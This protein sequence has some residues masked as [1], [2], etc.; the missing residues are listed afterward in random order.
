MSRDYIKSN[1]V[2]IGLDPQSKTNLYDYVASSAVIPIDVFY[3]SSLEQAISA[4]ITYL[5]NKREGSVYIPADVNNHAVYISARVGKD[6]QVDINYSTVNYRFPIN[7]EAR[8]YSG[9]NWQ[10]GDIIINNDISDA[11]CEGWV[12][13]EAG[14]PGT[15]QAF[16]YIRRWFT[17]IEQLD[18]LPEPGPMQLSRQVMSGGRVYICKLVDG[19]YAWYWMDYAYGTT[20][21][22]PTTDLRKGLP[23]YNIQTGLPEW[24]NGNEWVAVALADHT[25]DSDATDPIYSEMELSSAD[26]EYLYLPDSTEGFCDIQVRASDSSGANDARLIVLDNKFEVSEL[27]A[28]DSTDSSFE[29][30]DGSG[31]NLVNSVG[32]KEIEVCK[33]DLQLDPYTKYKYSHYQEF[34]SASTKIKIDIL[35]TDGIDETES[36]SI[37]LTTSD[38]YVTYD[39]V[40]KR[41]GRITITYIFRSDSSINDILYLS[42]IFLVPATGNYKFSLKDYLDSL[43][44]SSLY[45]F[46][47]IDNNPDELDNNLVIKRVGT[48]LIND[49]TYDYELVNSDT[50]LED[51]YLQFQVNLIGTAIGDS[52][53]LPTSNDTAASLNL[54]TEF[55]S[56]FAVSAY[57]TVQAGSSSQAL[58]GLSTEG[59]LLYSI[60][61]SLIGDSIISNYISY[62]TAIEGY[63][64][65]V[66]KEPQVT[67]L[68]KYPQVVR[69]YR[70]GVVRHDTSSSMVINLKYPANAAATS[71]SNSKTIDKLANQS[72]IPGNAPVSWSSD[73]TWD[74]AAQDNTDWR[75]NING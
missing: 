66:Y 3:Q 12:C 2:Q 32:G 28:V 29:L 56:R 16:G 59:I 23:Y 20:A 42:E 37:D 62:I 7:S 49:P 17:E 36:D 75:G 35:G 61:K 10:I 15:W 8:P 38:Q 11:K 5:T 48:T 63:A 25:H 43:G 55:T 24:Y 69:N 64:K 52:T 53:N 71:E 73:L 46:Y 50:Y 31:A 26:N 21:Q 67:R 44:A 34:E 14:T 54:P 6:L 13:I 51:D 68:A 9:G 72:V 30:I 22:R 57:S 39:F 27:E 41:S 33:L 40:T 4:A 60:P 58:V 45:P 47:S 70:N 65:V 18:Q 1:V 74:E 19:E